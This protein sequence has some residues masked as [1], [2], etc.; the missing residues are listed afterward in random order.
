MLSV[1]QD[2]IKYHILW[3]FGMTRPGIEPRSPGPLAYTLIIRPIMNE[4][5]PVINRTATTT[6]PTATITTT[7]TTT[8]NNNNDNN[9]NNK[10]DNNN[11]CYVIP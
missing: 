3:V 7:T 4:I 11:N 10:N 8:N 2:S 1:K 5:L 6:T 9:A